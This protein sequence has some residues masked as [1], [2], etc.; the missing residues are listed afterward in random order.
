MT[1]DVRW[2]DEVLPALEEVGQLRELR[3]IQP[4]GPWILS[5]E[6]QADF[7]GRRLALSIDVHPEHPG[8][9]PIIRVKDVDAV[10]RLP[11]VADDGTICYHET[12]GLSSS[13]WRPAAVV[14]AA[15]GRAMHTLQEGLL[16]N[17]RG[18]LVTEAEWYWRRQGAP[19]IAISYLRPSDKVKLVHVSLGPGAVLHFDAPSLKGGL[20]S[21]VTGTEHDRGLFV[22]L[23]QTAR[24]MGL[25]VRQMVEISSLR[26]IVHRHT[27]LENQKILAA[28]LKKF[29]AIRWLILG[30]PRSLQDWALLGLDLGLVEG[31]HPLLRRS[32]SAGV[33]L[34]FAIQRLDREHVL[35]RGGASMSMAS[36]KVAIIGCG[37]VGG[38]VAS[39]L[40]RAGVGELLLVDPERLEVANLFRHVLGRLHVGAYKAAALAIVL[41]LDVPY[42]TVRPDLRRAQD[43]LRGDPTLLGRFDAIVNATGDVTVTRWLNRELHSRCPARIVHTWLEPLGLGGHALLT[44]EGGAPGCYECLFVGEDGQECLHARSDLAAPD[45]V[46]HTMHAACGGAYT[47]YADLDARRTA[48]LTARLIVEALHGR[49]PEP[50]LRTWKSDGWRFAEAGFRTSSR[51]AI[52]GSELEVGAVELVDSRCRVCGG[53]R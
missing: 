32:R 1:S 29:P 23:S 52:A 48:D 51:F 36:K 5:I 34:P 15:L 53:H 22:P 49:S 25:D 26:A 6:G 24:E 12:V 17:N 14:V 45:Q 39:A 31:L 40:A 41:G 35:T 8:V 44:A 9:L 47:P 28:R 42:L 3:I 21:L 50:R 13:L 33:C 43:L 7:A 46:F 4:D 37:S 16:G 27:I 30:V 18:D 11:H 2:L 20:D 19:T 10:A 38:H